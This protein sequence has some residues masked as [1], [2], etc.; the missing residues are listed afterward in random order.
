MAPVADLPATIFEITADGRTKTV[1]VLALSPE[2]HPQDVPIITAL[3]H[4][5]E[6]LTNFANDIAGEQLYVPPAYRGTLNKVDQP[7]GPVIAWPWTDLAPADFSAG[8]NEFLMTHTLTPAQVTTLGIPGVEGG[9]VGVTLQKDGAIYSFS[10][11]PLLP[12]EPK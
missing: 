1:S 3:A 11:R 12:D 6:R 8:A 2:M 9:L 10:L 5:A 7:F 4:L